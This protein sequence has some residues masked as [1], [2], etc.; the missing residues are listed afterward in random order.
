L[1][2][3]VRHYRFVALVSAMSGHVPLAARLRLPGL[4]PCAVT[5]DG[6]R[7]AV[8]YNCVRWGIHDLP[9]QAGLG[10]YER[11]EDGLL[12]AAC[13]YGDVEAPAE[14]SGRGRSRQ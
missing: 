11:G 8:E 12:T 9:P 1:R 5:D 13:V 6:V 3:S 4:Q 2:I 7:C 10:V 14:L